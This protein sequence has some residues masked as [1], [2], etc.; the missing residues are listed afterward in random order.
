M[1]YINQFPTISISFKDIN[2]KDFSTNVD[3]IREIIA[4][5][6]KKH[7][8]IMNS[9]LIEESDRYVLN[10]LILEKSSYANL[11]TSLKRITRCLWTLYG[12]KTIVLIDE[13][14]V[15]LHAAFQYGYYEEMVDFIRGLLSNVFKSNTYLE[16][17][18]L[19]GCLRVSRES[20]FT[21]LNNL[22][23]YSTS[24]RKNSSYFGFTIEEVDALLNYY[25]MYHHREMIRNWYDGYIFGG[26]E[27]YNPWSV[28]LCIQDIMNGE[29]N[30]P[31][32]YWIN[33]SSN[34]I[35]KEYIE[36]SDPVMKLEFEQLVEGK[37]I[38]KRIKEE[39][40]YREMENINNIYSFLLFTGYLKEVRRSDDLSVL[41]IPNKEVRSVY[42]NT[43]I[44][45]FE[46]VKRESKR[47]IIHSFLQKDVNRANELLNELFLK[48]ISFYDSY[49]SFYHGL[50]AGLFVGMD[51]IVESNRECGDGR[52]D[53]V[54]LPKNYLKQG[55]IIECKMSHS[56][57]ELEK[58]AKRALNQIRRGRYIEGLKLRGYLNMVGYGISFYKKSCYIL[59]L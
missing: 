8:E 59:T 39:L 11:L 53:L 40:T 1:K 42:I 17:G 36:K 26:E 52:F 6:L 20:I 32:S 38:E 31:Q 49:E 46:D 14:D 30:V 4:E 28:L 24:S 45:W 56:L 27:I 54:V 29:Y 25:D 37:T 16:K 57:S 7:K 22:R 23:V 41:E 10:E 13:Y 2:N 51:F 55:F 9:P 43:F 19:T 3:L 48:S 35:I 15:P 18:I 5:Q 47:S 58:D 21:G 33:T 12:K 50:L 34:T 44:D